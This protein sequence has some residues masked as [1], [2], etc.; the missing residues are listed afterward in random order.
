[1][2]T[3]DN[4]ISTRTRF[5]KGRVL[6]SFALS[7]PIKPQLDQSNETYETI[8]QGEKPYVT[9]PPVGGTTVDT[10]VCTGAAVV[11]ITPTISD[12]SVVV[13]GAFFVCTVT[14]TG[15]PMSV[16]WYYITGSGPTKN[17]TPF[18]DDGLDVFGSTTT[19]LTLDSTLYSGFTIV[20]SGPDPCAEGGG[21]TPSISSNEV[22]LSDA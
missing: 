6:A 16:Q 7:G 19:Q 11:C 10:C 12:V 9:Q 2:P 4:S 18:T 14:L 17:S 22:T 3:T 20:C 1:M 5:I 8:Q 13:N 15:S 21:A